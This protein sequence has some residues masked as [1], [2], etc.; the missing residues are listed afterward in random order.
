[1]KQFYELGLSDE[2]IKA[3]EDLKFEE[4][5]KVQRE[6][7]P[8]VLEGRDVIVSSKTGSGKTF[9]FSAG[10]L[11]RMDLSSKGKNIKALILTPTRELAEQVKNHLLSFSKYKGFYIAAIY[12]GVSF[13]PQFNALRKADI[14]VGTPGRVLDH[15]TRGTMDLSELQYVVLDEA[16]RML[17]MGFFNDVNEILSH[18]SKGFQF[19]MFSATIDKQAEQIAKRFAK[20]PKRIILESFVD[21][22]QLNQY[23]YDVPHKLKFSLLVHLIKSEDAQ[24][25]MV[26]CNSRRMVD[27]VSYGL[28]KEGIK[29]Y[30][31]HGGLTQ[32]GR[33]RILES[34]SNR[35]AVLVCTDVAARG[36]DIKDVT[37]VYNYDLPDDIKRYVHRIG[38]TARVDNKGKVIN[39]ISP[40]DYEAFDRILNEYSF[41]VERLERPYLEP[42]NLSSFNKTNDFGRR[43]RNYN[44]FRSNS[45]GKNASHRKKNN[46][47]IKKKNSYSN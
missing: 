1:M 14:V 17:D 22:K 29:A 12:G 37:H 44:D 35:K 4:P 2:L 16:D 23:Y 39:L 31:I 45:R 8:Y 9:A 21:P 40:R 42:I 5:T 10:I 43:N 13:E 26:F 30:G 41:R 47:R 15:L 24:R 36:L 20:D 38:R 3:V 27:I 25:T 28:Q 46:K 19:L 7:I 6:S 32:N 34:F 18:A 11:Q 33:K